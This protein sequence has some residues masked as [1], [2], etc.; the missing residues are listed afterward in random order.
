MTKQDLIK[1]V[2]TASSL[3]QAD[4]EKVLNTLPIVASQ[5][6]KAGEE[7]ILPGIGKLKAV[8][9]EARTGRNPQNG[10][11]V[12]IAAKTVVKFAAVKAFKDAL[13]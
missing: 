5:Q 4:V 7:V 8:H 13:N 12:E 11:A 1:A 3:T 6:L 10:E 2:A 9:K